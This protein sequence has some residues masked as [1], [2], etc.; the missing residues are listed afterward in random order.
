MNTKLIGAILLVAGVAIGAGMLGMPVVTGLAGFYPSLFAMISC[1]A[2]LLVTGFLMVDVNISLSKEGGGVISMA[3]HTLGKWGKVFSWITYLFLLYALDIAFI[4]AGQN[5]IGKLCPTLPSSIVPL[6]IVI[7]LGLIISRGICAVDGVNRFLV[8]AKLVFGYGLLVLLVPPHVRASLLTHIDLNIIPF[9]LPF[10]LQAFGFHT[11][12]PS[13][14][15]Y[16][17]KDVRLIRAALTWGSLIALLVYAIWE[18]LVLGVVP[19]TGQVS[20]TNSY[21]QGQVS[22][23]PLT[24]LLHSPLIELGATLFGLLGVGTAFLGVT[25]SLFDCL[26]DGLNLPEGKK[27]RWIAVILTF[28]PPLVFV[29]WDHSLFLS[30]LSYAG[31]FVAILFGLFPIAMAWTLDS[32]FFWST[33]KGRVVLIGGALFF[34]SILGFDILSKIG[35]LIP[36]N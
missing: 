18:M 14:V 26:I 7:P 12:I 27:G 33:K 25:L 2:F 24:D 21:L 32:S 9:S 11:I 28:A 4:A 10:I 35:Y 29:Y 13:I 8:V 20:I 23:I 22:T 16:L 5:I 34:I 19:L 6:L 36:K 17:K 31:A 1:W 3:E 30:A 15:H